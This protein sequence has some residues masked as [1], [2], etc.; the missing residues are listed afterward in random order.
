MTAT[1]AGQPAKPPATPLATA[2]ARP[3]SEPPASADDDAARTTLQF[4]MIIGVAVF[5]LM[6]LVGLVMRS[7]QATFIALDPE[8]FYRLMTLHGAG[9]VGA[10]GLGGTMVMW[11]LLRRHVALS[12]GV[13][14]LMLALSLVGVVLIIASI[15]VGRFGAAWTF[16]YPLPAKSLGMWS[17]LAA[18]GF[19]VGLTL[20]GVGFLLFYGDCAMALVRSHGSLWCALGMPQLISG[21]MSGAPPITV[22]ASTMVIIVNVLGILGGAVV[23]VMTLVGLLLPGMV[24]DALLMKNLIYFFGHVFINAAIYMA[25]IAVYEILPLYTGKPWKVSRAVLAAWAAAVLLVTTVY[26]HHLLMDGAMPR[27]ALALGQVVSFMSGIPVLVVTAWGAL[28]NIARSGMRWSLPPAL[29]VLGVMG[30]AVGVV[31]AVID[32]TITVNKVMHNTLWV[33]GHFHTYLLLGLLPM[34]F[35]FMLHMVRATEAPAALDRVA[36]WLY[37]LG[38]AAFSL[39]F[40]YGG[41]MSVPRRFAEHAPQWLASS[42]IGSVAGAVVILAAVWLV[43]RVMLKLPATRM[44]PTA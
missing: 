19:V 32:A 33:P 13:Y 41:V 23:L 7:T 6:M 15:L 28:A 40:L 22:V 1:A 30:W 16:L 11:A 12:T 38:A 21:D 42:T 39:S 36:F 2:S 17:P 43:L 5:A 27:W 29:L 34:L 14:R 9:M 20:I 18:A 10:A 4:T 25:V 8:L 3:P 31:P 35:G 24:F 37:A 26:P 44:A